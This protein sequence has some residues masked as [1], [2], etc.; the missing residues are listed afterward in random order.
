MA[1]TLII[2]PDGVVTDLAKTLET[3]NEMEVPDVLTTP[4]SMLTTDSN[5]IM[6][7]SKPGVAE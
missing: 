1:M 3:A 7:S 6:V 2:A 5:V 4:G